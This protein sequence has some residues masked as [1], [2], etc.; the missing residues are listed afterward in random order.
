MSRGERAMVPKAEVRTYYDQP[1]LKEPVWTWEI[2]AYLFTGGLAAGSA[3]LAAGADL[4]SNPSLARSMQCAA[5]AATAVSGGLLVADLGVPHR[6]HHMLRVIKPTSP[7]SV[8]SWLLTSFGTATAVAM[9][10]TLSGRF[11]TV[12]R[13]ARLAAAALAPAL[14]TYTGVLV[15]DTAVPAWHEASETLP[16]LF[17]AGAAASAGGLGVVLVDAAAGAPA[18]RLAVVGALGEVVAARAMRRRLGPLVGRPYGEGRT[19]R[20]RQLAE[21]CTVTGAVAVLAGRRRRPV[22]VVGGLLECAGAALERFAVV[23]AGR[24]SARDPEA[25]VSPQRARCNA[26]AVG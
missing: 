13:V 15:A 23:Q 22:L 4:T 11:A 12:G 1:V 10:S 3:L 26:S 16:M 25:T 8:G 19:R 14:A 17:A 24:D 9:T 18:R 21:A 20:L 7:M 5:L 2:P 6:A